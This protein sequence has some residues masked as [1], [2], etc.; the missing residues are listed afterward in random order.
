VAKGQSRRTF[1]SGGLCLG[2]TTL[3]AGPLVA[4]SKL[5][6]ADTTSGLP[7]APPKSGDEALTRLLAGNRHFVRGKLTHPGRDS[8]RRVEIAEGQKPFAIVLGCADSRVPPEVV[9]DQGLGDLF[10]VR[11][12]GNTAIDPLVVGSIEYAATTFGSVLAMVLGHDQCGA[13]KATIDVAVKG[14]TLPGDIG[15][16][17]DPII[18]AVEQVRDAPEGALLDQAT[19]ANIRQSVNAL[20][21]A[22]PLLT[23][24]VG[25]GKLKVVGAEYQLKS[26]KVD[27]VVQ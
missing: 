21:T 5:A 26:G 20:Q 7:A 15:A 17:V 25:S 18:P 11:V 4:G 27:M 16:V 6:R 2:G 1:L 19:R 3:A 22:Y 8:V 10:T 24:L 13:V 12:A 9:F 23:D 14:K